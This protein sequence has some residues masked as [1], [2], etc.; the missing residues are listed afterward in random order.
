MILPPTRFWE[1]F[2]ISPMLSSTS[3]QMLTIRGGIFLLMPIKPRNESID[4]VFIH[5]SQMEIGEN[6]HGS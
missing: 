2:A 6:S 5:V 4:V 1:L 3:E